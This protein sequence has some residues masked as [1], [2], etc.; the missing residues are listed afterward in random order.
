LNRRWFA[1]M[2]KVL[3]GGGGR[4]GEERRGEVR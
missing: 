2:R 4:R 1:N 3:K